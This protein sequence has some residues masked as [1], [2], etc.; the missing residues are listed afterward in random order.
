MNIMTEFFVINDDLQSS[1]TEL[2]TMN[3]PV[4]VI[5]R[6]RAPL[7]GREAR[8]V[9]ACRAAMGDRGLGAIIDPTDQRGVAAVALERGAATSSTASASGASSSG[10]LAAKKLATQRFAFDRVFGPRS[11]QD[12]L[13][14]FV[15]PSIEA[16]SRGF[17]ATIFAYG[18]TGEYTFSPSFF[19]SICD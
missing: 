8:A 2:Q 15:K 18:Q 12:D 9:A 3:Q 19:S 1:E 10:R 4:R 13:F 7:P 17:N 5:A 11:S 6:A 14:D 16:V